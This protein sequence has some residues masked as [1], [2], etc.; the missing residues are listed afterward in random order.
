MEEVK[1][2]YT[3]GV[4]IGRFQV[5]D[6]TKSHQALIEHV[7]QECN[8]TIILLGI[9][10]LKSTVNNPLDYE[11]RVQMIKK[12]FGDSRPVTISHI[13]DCYSDTEWSSRI[14]LV[15][16]DLVGCDFHEV[17]LYGGRDSFIKH[18][19]GQ[20]KTIEMRSDDQ[21]DS[22]TDIR[23]EARKESIDNEFFRRGVIWG[24][25]NQYKR[26]NPTVDVAIIKDNKILL[27]RKSGEDKWRFIGGFAS[28]KTSYE[29]DAKRE[30]QE[31]TG[32]EVADLTYVG[33]YPVDDWRVRSEKKV[34][35]MTVLFKA[36]YVFGMVEPADD[37][38][39]AEWFLFEGCTLPSI[40]PAH[41]EMFLDLLLKEK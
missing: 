7:G 27:G 28:G 39:E 25:N 31:E 32:M 14:D 2:K 1:A 15:I 9:S 33:S 3:V 16:R 36:I 37:I 13:A 26:V 21:G 40:I 30:V 12:E 11:Q 38:E 24:V 4:I 6:L 19:T 35:I 17:A 22:G 8:R 29:L 41:R 23:E 18:Y 34:S 20:F 5:P 10:P